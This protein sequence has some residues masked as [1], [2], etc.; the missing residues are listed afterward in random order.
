MMKTKAQDLL[1]SYATQLD[2]FF[3]VHQDAN[4]ALSDWLASH[5]S[6][7]QMIEL[8]EAILKDTSS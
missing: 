7:T 4:T 6:N 8:L 2:Q 3:A 5:F 1:H